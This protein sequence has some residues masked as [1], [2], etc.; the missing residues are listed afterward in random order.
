[1]TRKSMKQLLLYFETIKSISL[2]LSHVEV[3]IKTNSVMMMTTTRSET[4]MGE[5]NKAVST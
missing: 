2:T 1:M 5:T 3:G 4:G